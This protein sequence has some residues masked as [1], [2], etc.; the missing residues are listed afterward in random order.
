MSYSWTLEQDYPNIDRMLETVSTWDY[1][2][3]H[4]TIA[5][6][7]S[8]RKASSAN[9]NRS[10]RK[11]KLE[12][13]RPTEKKSDWARNIRRDE[14]IPNQKPLWLKFTAFLAYA[15]KCTGAW[16][17]EVNQGIFHVARMHNGEYLAYFL[18]GN[19]QITPLFKSRSF[20]G[21]MNQLCR[22]DGWHSHGSLYALYPTI[23]WKADRVPRDNTQTLTHGQGY[24]FWWEEDYDYVSGAT[25]EIKPEPKYVP[26][27]VVNGEPV[28]E[29]Y[30]RPV[31]NPYDTL[32]PVPVGKHVPS[33]KAKAIIEQYQERKVSN[34]DAPSNR[35]GKAMTR[36]KKRFADGKISEEHIAGIEKYKPVGHAVTEYEEHEL[37]SMFKPTTK[38]GMNY[39]FT[40]KGKEVYTNTRTS[41]N[42]RGLMNRIDNGTL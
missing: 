1:P 36:R 23:H 14:L 29:P 16:V 39:V 15:K 33:P 19:H 12:I 3:L 22:W 34:P 4:R 35:K 27:L 11:S 24:W 13:P 7:H 6:P 20:N 2:R 38:H 26:R 31:V 37:L 28:G 40:Y 41:F 5:D 10:A 18:S 42:A 17:C 30:K 21:V 9:A 25:Q 32:F 8:F